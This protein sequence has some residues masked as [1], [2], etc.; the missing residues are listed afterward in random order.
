MILLKSIEK[1]DTKMYGKHFSSMYEGS[2]IGAGAHVFAVWGYCIANADPD[3]HTVRLNPKL[4]AIILGEDEGQIISAIEFLA[5]A[6]P[7]SCCPD[8]DGARLLNTSGFEY[9]VV[10]HAQYR[11]IKNSSDRREYMRK[12]MRE[13][14]GKKPDVN[15]CK[16]VNINKFTSV[17]VSVS[18]SDIKGVSYS[19]A[20]DRWNKLA[21]RCKLGHIRNITSKRRKHYNARIAENDDFWDVLENEIS[22]L[23]AFALG[24]N[25]TKWQITFDF[26][27]RS[28]DNFNKLAE[29]NYRKQA[30]KGSNI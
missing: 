25:D 20:T 11:D 9:L 13:Y 5:Q 30:P 10:S 18:E 29:G 22:N 17:S 1:G 12:Y 7:N 8:Y 16:D 2:M 6:D 14:R 21:E 28:Q 15:S 26:C 27:V 3:L 4:L 24:S 23:G 19:D